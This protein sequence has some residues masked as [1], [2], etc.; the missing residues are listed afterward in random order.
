MPHHPAHNQAGAAP[1]A[2]SAPTPLDVSPGQT[3]V[4]LG[5]SI[6]A[7]DPGFV[8]VLQQALAHTRPELGLRVIA[9]GVPGD[10]VDNLLARLPDALAAHPA[11][12]VICIGA[13]DYRAGAEPGLAPFLAAY[14]GLIGRLREAGATPILMTIP[15]IEALDANPP[16]PDPR[17][18]NAAIEALAAREGLRVVDLYRAFYEVHERAANYKQRVALSS[19]GIHPNS[20]GHTLIA[21]TIL[22]QLGLLRK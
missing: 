17:A 9:A 12:V 11:W 16:I 1:A 18:Y 19:D 13:N 3:M 14:A 5:D 4:F 15:V 6:T 20:Q 8:G 2:A 21:R 10:T 7:A 22:T